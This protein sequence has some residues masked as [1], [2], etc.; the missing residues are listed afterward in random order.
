M[1]RTAVRNV[2]VD[3]LLS[4]SPQISAVDLSEVVDGRFSHDQISRTLYRGEVD[5]KTLY[6]KGKNFIKQKGVEG[7]VRVS[8]DD[9]IQPKPYREIKGVVN[10][11]YD[12]TLGWCVK[13]H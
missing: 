11:Q 3:Y 7:L 13:G 10:W 1:G 2:Y 6:V 5:D 8:I 12:H 4:G 9:S